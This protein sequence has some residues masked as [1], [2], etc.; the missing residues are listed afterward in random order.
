M[1]NELRKKLGLN[2]YSSYSDY[3]DRDEDLIKQLDLEEEVLNEA[4]N[5]MADF[6]HYSFN[7]TIILTREAS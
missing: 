5:V 7:P 3:L 4:A 6:I 2:T 1:E